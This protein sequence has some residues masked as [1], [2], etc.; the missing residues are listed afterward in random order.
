MELETHL[1]SW[2][3][4]ENAEWPARGNKTVKQIRLYS[5]SKNQDLTFMRHEATQD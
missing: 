5:K 4:D 1:S 2:R 3:F